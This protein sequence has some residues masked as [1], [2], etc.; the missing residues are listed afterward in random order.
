MTIFLKAF[1]VGG[2]TTKQRP[3]EWWKSTGTSSYFSMMTIWIILEYIVSHILQSHVLD[4]LKTG[5]SAGLQVFVP[6]IAIFSPSER[7][8]VGFGEAIDDYYSGSWVAIS[9]ITLNGDLARAAQG[10]AGGSGALEGG[11]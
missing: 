6:Q 5:K 8:G 4:S 10:A 1:G 9:T 3:F 7:H 2:F 11:G